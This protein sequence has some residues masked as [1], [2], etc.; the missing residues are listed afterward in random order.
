MDWR[1]E[2]K[3]ALRAY[4]RAKRKQSENEQQITPAYGGA[5]VQ[6]SASR[7]TEDAALRQSLSAY[8]ESVI[9]AVEFMLRMQRTYPNAEQRM[10]M[11]E[12]VHFRRTHTII[13]AA[14]I[15]HYSPDALWRWNG[16]ILTAVY[17]GLRKEQ[18][19]FTKN[20]TESVV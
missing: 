8:E 12:L 6:H 15:V 4:P 16:E 18:K 7:T 14:E 19:N 5:A 17:V 20:S 2:A 3:A 1:R 9:A 10:K 13:G 11:I